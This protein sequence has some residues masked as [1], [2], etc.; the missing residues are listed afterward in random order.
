MLSN[1][2]MSNLQYLT[3]TVKIVL[4]S[5]DY[6]LLLIY[7]MTTVCSRTYIFNRVYLNEAMFRFTLWFIIQPLFSYVHYMF[8]FTF[9]FVLNFFYESKFKFKILDINDILR[10]FWSSIMCLYTYNSGYLYICSW[11]DKFCTCAL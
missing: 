3:I 4:F 1:V 7:G 8:S 9:P 11:M 2:N 10:Y 6:R 5:F